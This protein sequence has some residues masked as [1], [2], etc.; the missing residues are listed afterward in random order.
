MKLFLKRKSKYWWYD[1]TVRGERFRGSTK[2]THHTRAEGIAA[3]KFAAVVKEGDPLKGKPPTLRQYSKTFLG[4][5]DSGRLED[6]SRRYYRNG[7]RLLEKLKIAGMRMDKISKRQIEKLRF[8]GSPSNGNNALRTLR[9]MFSMAVEDKLITK[10]PEFK[11]FKERGRSLRLND[12][13]ERLLMP[14]AEQPLKDVIVVMRDTGQRNGRELYCMRVENIDFDAGTITIP[15]SKTEAG[16]R[17]VPITPRVEGILRE[18]CAGRIQGWVW[19][20][21]YKGKHIGEAMLNRQWVRARE[22]AGLPPD[23]VLYCARH[24]YGSFVLRTT[25]NLKVV[26]DLMGQRDHRTALKYQHHGIEV[27]REALKSRHIPRHTGEEG[28]LASD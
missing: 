18:R 17:S 24:D 27:A 1:F 7:W 25:G 16:T 4:W 2:E 9:R 3:L 8:P 23:L 15:D 21:R 6:D 26:M 22:A 19:Q 14:V 5:V 10:A 11:L 12:A 28:V 13:A 20:S